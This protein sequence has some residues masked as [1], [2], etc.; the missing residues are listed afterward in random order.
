MSSARIMRMFGF[1]VAACE[2]Q[3]VAANVRR[4]RSER[5]NFKRAA[6]GQVGV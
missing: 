2:P 6:M 1:D 3:T 4:R 5:E